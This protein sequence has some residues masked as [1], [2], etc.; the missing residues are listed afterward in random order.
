VKAVKSSS[1]YWQERGMIFWLHP[2]N[3]SGRGAFCDLNVQG[4]ATLVKGPFPHR[5]RNITS[6]R[7]P[8]DL[9][10]SAQ[11]CQPQ[12]LSSTAGK[13]APAPGWTTCSDRLTHTGMVQN[14]SHKAE[15]LLLGLFSLEKR[16]LQRDLIGAFQNLKGD[17]KQEENKPRRCD[18]TRGNV[19]KLKERR[20]R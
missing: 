4:N 3:L 13:P 16:R 20:F 2:S 9:Y 15:C 11:S 5:S 19:L 7:P 8:K 14:T 6:Q 1:I 12:Q 18:K 17:Y 10:F